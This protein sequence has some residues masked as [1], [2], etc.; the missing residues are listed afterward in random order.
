MPEGYDCSPW[1]RGCHDQVR[2]RTGTGSP[3]SD[4]YSIPGENPGWCTDKKELNSIEE[5]MLYCLNMHSH[6]NETAELKF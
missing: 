5:A 1:A 3:Q 6:K 2:I 4:E